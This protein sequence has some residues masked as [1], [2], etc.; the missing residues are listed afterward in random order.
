MD[1]GGCWRNVSEKTFDLC[2]DAPGL[3]SAYVVAAVTALLV[4]LCI[5][6]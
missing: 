3:N 4:C 1:R 2:S 6:K 5:T